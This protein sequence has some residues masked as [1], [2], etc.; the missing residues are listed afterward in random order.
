MEFKI[1][2]VRD[3]GTHIPVMAIQMQSETALQD[4]YIHHRSGYPKDGSSIVVMILGTCKATND[5]YE[6]QSLGLGPRTL[7]VAH[8]WIIDRYDEVHDGDV[9]DVQFILGETQAPKVSERF[10]QRITVPTPEAAD[11]EFDVERAR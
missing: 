1:L 3:S 10:D 8:N 2:E 9:V 4:Y 7:P 6:W 11:V 5:P